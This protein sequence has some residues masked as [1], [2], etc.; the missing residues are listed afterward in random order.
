[1]I[2]AKN[3]PGEDEHA[4]VP[5][6]TLTRGTARYLTLLGAFLLIFPLSFVVMNGLLLR[7]WNE[8][9]SWP[10]HPALIERVDLNEHWTMASSQH[11]SRLVYRLKGAYRYQVD[12]STFEGTRLSL[13]PASDNGAYNR[14]LFVRLDQARSAQQK[15]P[16]YVNPLNPSDSVLVRDL[17]I[18][19]LIKDGLGAILL[20]T[21][22]VWLIRFARN[23]PRAG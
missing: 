6:I 22:G 5:P 20:L 23:A 7:E 1:M 21:L 13:Y 10:E 9:Q 19:K 2:A 17:R 8:V 18:P 12:R 15:M 4:V 14:K 3:V 11:S 16:C